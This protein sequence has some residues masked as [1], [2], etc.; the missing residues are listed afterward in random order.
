VDVDADIE[1]RIELT[2]VNSNYNRRERS[3]FLYFRATSLYL[4]YHDHDLLTTKFFLRLSIS[5]S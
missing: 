4:Q 2:I 5:D 1:N 3:S